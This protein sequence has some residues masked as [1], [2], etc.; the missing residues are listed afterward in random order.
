MKDLTGIVIYD[1]GTKKKV[2]VNTVSRAASLARDRNEQVD[3]F[4][5]GVIMG[6]KAAGSNRINWI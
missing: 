6:L 3:I 5:D 2:A 4:K 1:C